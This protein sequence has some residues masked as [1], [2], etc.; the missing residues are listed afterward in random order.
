MTEAQ[1]TTHD[2]H[3]IGHIT[4]VSLLLGIFALLIVLTVLTVAVTFVDLGSANIW[5]ALG[6]AVVKA[7]LVALY[8][9]HLR[10]DAPFNG[11]I[12]VSAF[13]FLAIFIGISLMD[14]GEYSEATSPPPTIRAVGG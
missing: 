14:T 7:G 2:D 1:T 6:V 9:M 4:P 8:F 11:L 13:L 12:L 5:I 3:G 10:Y